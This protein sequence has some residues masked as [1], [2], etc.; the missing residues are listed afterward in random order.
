MR[1]SA[2]A[3][4]YARAVAS[5]NVAPARAGAIARL[6]ARLADMDDQP[7][8]TPGTLTDLQLKSLTRPAT[9]GW[10]S[11]QHFAQTMRADMEIIAGDVDIDPIRASAIV[12]RLV[13][14]GDL[15]DQPEGTPGVLTDLQ[16]EFLAQGAPA[17]WR[18]R[19][20]FIQKFRADAS[21]LAGQLPLEA[22]AILYRQHRHSD[23]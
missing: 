2:G 18:D 12:Q 3:A 1:S 11:R 10:Q 22:P 7:D 6:L 13:C 9:A 8:G 14:L 5:F 19:E 20:D 16:L 4:Q 15:A 23:P 17:G 21:S